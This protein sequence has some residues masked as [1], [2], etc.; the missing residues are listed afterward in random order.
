MTNEDVRGARYPPCADLNSAGM[1]CG[2]RGMSGP[3]G[4]SLGTKSPRHRPCWPRK[5]L[6]RSLPFTLA[7]T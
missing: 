5:S 3:P 7:Q 6:P 2:A 4:I 1:P